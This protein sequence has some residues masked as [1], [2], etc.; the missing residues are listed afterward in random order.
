MQPPSSEQ[1]TEFIFKPPRPPT[2]P[3][4]LGAAV[5]A[6]QA[7]EAPIVVKI[8]ELADPA[9]GSFLWPSAHPLAWWLWRHAD[10]VRGKRILE[11]RPGAA[12][13]TSTFARSWAP[14]R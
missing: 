5:L 4:L 3:G 1:V 13:A 10:L 9:F 11:V 14:A 6:A 8:R 12:A 7:A 2:A